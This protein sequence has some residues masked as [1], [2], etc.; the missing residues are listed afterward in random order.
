MKL[1]L[2]IASDL[3]ELG[4]GQIVVDQERK[5][6]AEC[7]TVADAKTL[8]YIINSYAQLIHLLVEIHPIS[9][10]IGNRQGDLSTYFEQLVKIRGLMSG[11]PVDAI[12]IAACPTMHDYIKA[13]ASTGDQAAQ[14]IIDSLR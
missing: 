1:P 2:F 7:L 12:L 13:M 3:S 14:K 10:G 8:V 5:T 9:D 4:A 6:I 11:L